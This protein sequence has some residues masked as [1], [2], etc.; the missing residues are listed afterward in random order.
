MSTKP[1]RIRKSRS[2]RGGYTAAGGWFSD[3]GLAETYLRVKQAQAER[4]ERTQC[5]ACNRRILIYAIGYGY[6]A[7]APALRCVCGRL[8]TLADVKRMDDREQR[9]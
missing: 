5:P 3:R 2:Q 6:V 4:V 8:V 7:G 9:T 1:L